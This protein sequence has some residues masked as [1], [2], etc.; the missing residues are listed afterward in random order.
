[1]LTPPP[2]AFTVAS[3][4]IPPFT[5]GRVNSISVPSGQD[6]AAGVEIGFQ[7]MRKDAVPTLG[8]NETVLTASGFCPLTEP[9]VGVVGSGPNFPMMRGVAY[10]LSEQRD[11]DV[12]WMVN[13]AKYPVAVMLPPDCVIESC[14][15]VQVGP[16]WAAGTSVVVVVLRGMEPAGM[17]P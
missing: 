5:F 16:A 4:V 2:Q 17:E 11:L 14:D 13:W 8:A 15:L 1:M 12:L 10:P 7:D 6:G 9:F 3:A